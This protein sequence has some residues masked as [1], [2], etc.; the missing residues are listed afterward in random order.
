MG[1]HDSHASHHSGHP[2]ALARG[3]S[4][5]RW[6]GWGLAGLLC[7]AETWPVLGALAQRAMRVDRRD[8]IATQALPE[9]GSGIQD[10][11]EGG[12]AV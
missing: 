8:L 6:L 9:T 4:V 7:P 12:W 11:H 10:R 1:Y 5:A 2:L 3:R